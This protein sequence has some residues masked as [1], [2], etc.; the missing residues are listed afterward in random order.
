MSIKVNDIFPTHIF[1][2]S[3]DNYEKVNDKIENYLKGYK[4]RYPSLE[5]SN[6]GG[7]HTRLDLH[8]KKKFKEI[9]E[10]IVFTINQL[11]ENFYMSIKAKKIIFNENH[12][13][14][15]WGMING[16]GHYNTKHTHPPC[17]LSGA[18]YVKLTEDN[19]FLTFHDPLAVRKHESLYI[20]KTDIMVKE[21]DLLIFPGWLEHSVAENTSNEER[22]VLSFNLKNINQNG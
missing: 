12:I 20:D 16:K 2:T 9:N 13:V 4:K 5:K 11:I 19:S 1:R 10:L 15:M 8:K 18:Y 7:Y 3:L 14:S 17:F 6:Y 22:I 21:G